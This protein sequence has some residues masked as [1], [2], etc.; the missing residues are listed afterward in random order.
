MPERYIVPSIDR[1][2]HVLNLLAQHGSL[3]LS[4]LVKLSAIPKTSLYRILSTLEQRRAVVSTGQGEYR[5]GSKMLELSSHYL[6][7]FE[8]HRV[9]I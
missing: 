3:G 6:D 7:G 8:F 4:D 2:F 9:A 5:L 1:A